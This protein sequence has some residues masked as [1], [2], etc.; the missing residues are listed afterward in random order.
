M[1]DTSISKRR[2]LRAARLTT[3]LAA[4]AGGALIASPASAQSVCQILPGGIVSCPAPVPPL[5]DPVIPT[6]TAV[7]DITGSALPILVTLEDGFVSDG[8]INLG[9]LAGADIDIVS[10]GVSTINSVG[11]GLTAISGRN[12]TAEVTNISTVGDG[13]I[14]ALLRAADTLI[15]T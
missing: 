6:T 1:P 13:A 8:P 7:I 4:G 3:I 14:G 11:T 5:P 12:L 15:F 10:E 2:V 9:T